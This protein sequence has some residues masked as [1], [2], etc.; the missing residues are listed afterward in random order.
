MIL[1]PLIKTVLIIEDDLVLA[2]LFDEILN[3]SFC[4]KTT[5]NISDAITCMQN[6]HIDAVITDYHLGVQNADALIDWILQKRPELAAGTILMTGESGTI[7][8]HRHNIAAV[9]FKP[10][11]FNTLELTVHGLFE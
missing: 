3:T 1:P 8:R 5:H 6:T 9:L 4:V 10:V 2:E 11:D 7:T